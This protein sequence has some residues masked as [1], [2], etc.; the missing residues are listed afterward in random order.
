[1]VVGCLRFKQ[2]SAYRAL[3]D[4]LSTLDPTDFAPDLLEDLAADQLF[5]SGSWGV[6]R[7]E[8]FGQEAPQGPVAL[9]AGSGAVSFILLKLFFRQHQLPLLTLI[10]DGFAGHAKLGYY[11]ET[12]L[13]RVEQHMLAAARIRA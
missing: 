13:R 10:A 1:V 2:V 8:S 12:E 9:V 11:L 4:R 3:V 7:V 5:H 6:V